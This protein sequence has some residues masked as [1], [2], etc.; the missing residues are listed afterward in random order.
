M[1]DCSCYF[2]LLPRFSRPGLDLLF[3]ELVRLIGD[4]QWNAWFFLGGWAI[5]LFVEYLFSHNEVLTEL[6]ELV[7]TLGGR[8][9]SLDK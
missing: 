7:E 6:C 1:Y 8:V 4:V 9:K 5:T 2:F 3:S